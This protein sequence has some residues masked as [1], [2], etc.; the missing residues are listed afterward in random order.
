MSKFVYYVGITIFFLY[1]TALPER[2]EPCAEAGR[3][4][5]SNGLKHPLRYLAADRGGDLREAFRWSE[6]IK[7]RRQQVRQGC[8]NFLIS[9]SRVFLTKRASSIPNSGTPSALCKTCATFSSVNGTAVGWT[10]VMIR[11]RSSFAKGL[12]YR[13][14]E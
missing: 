1:H 3:R 4:Y 10:F 11:R 8:G 2:L 5:F 13:C 14:V 7:T 12:R 9:G 6:S